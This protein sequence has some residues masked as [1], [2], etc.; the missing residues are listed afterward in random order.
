MNRPDRKNPMEAISKRYLN[1]EELRGPIAKLF[2]GLQKSMGMNPYKWTRYLLD[3]LAWVV[4]EPNEEK[5][6]A[7]ILMK[8]G[9]IRDAYFH[10]PT[11]TADKLLEGLSILQMEECKITMEVRNAKGEVWVVEETVKIKHPKNGTYDGTD[12]PD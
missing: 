12:E 7:R 10:K 5:R 1:D 11:L 3:Y 4:S 9:N 8:T 6:K 2:R